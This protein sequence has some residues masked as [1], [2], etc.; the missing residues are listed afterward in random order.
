MQGYELNELTNGLPVAMY[1][2]KSRTDR[3]L[4]NVTDEEV[5]SR[6]EKTLTDLARQLHVTIGEIY[7]E[8]VSG[9]TIAARPKMQQLLED[10]ESGR[11]GGILVVE[12]ERLARGNSI[13]QGIL[14]QAMVYTGCKILTPN[15]VYDPA[16]EMDEEYFEFG[17]FMSR[18]EYNTIR[19]RL[20]SGRRASVSEG[21][22]VGSVAPYGYVRKKMEGQKGYSLAPDP[23]ESEIVREIFRLYTVGEEMPDGT[24][25]RIGA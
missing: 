6:H 8:V 16:N 15:K 2:R 11:W 18:R 14:S 24:V 7:R 1:L 22:Y 23:I 25:Q 17:L 12:V 21:K 9:E 10:I 19:R 13:D 20:M 4:P 5:L 3:D